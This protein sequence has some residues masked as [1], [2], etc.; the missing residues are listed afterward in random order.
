[1]S[2]L[3]PP[4]QTLLN[5]QSSIP[6]PYLIPQLHLNEAQAQS[7]T[8]HL[9]HMQMQAVVAYGQQIS[10]AQH[11]AQQ[12]MQK[13][14]PRPLGRTQSAPLPLGHPAL[15]GLPGATAINITTLA[16]MIAT[17]MIE[18]CSTR[19]TAVITESNEKTIS[20]RAI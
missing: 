14:G 10:E 8:A 1:M 4:S 16:R 19:P 18:T 13:P 7:A 2:Q 12:R 17:A 9:N 11:A 5:H 3:R 15:S 6:A 20:R